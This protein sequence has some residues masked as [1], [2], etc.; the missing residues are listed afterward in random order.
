MQKVIDF[1][2]GSRGTHFYEE[3]TPEKRPQDDTMDGRGLTFETLEHH[4]C[5]LCPEVIRV[6]DAHGRNCLYEAAEEYDDASERP[7]DEDGQGTSLRF[8]P[9]SHGGDY[10][11]KMPQA[12]RVTDPERR[13][14]LYRPISI[15][16]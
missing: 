10:P 5:D 2:D 1:S 9:E 16:G 11:D 8:E 14:C 15:D 6:T 13:S 12:I 4:G 3:L 7:H